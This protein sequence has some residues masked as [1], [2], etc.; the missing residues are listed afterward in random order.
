MNATRLG[1]TRLGAAPLGLAGRGSAP[2][3]AA[4]LGAAMCGYAPQGKGNT[5]MTSERGKAG[6]GQAKRGSTLQCMILAMRVLAL[7]SRA[8]HGK[9]R[10]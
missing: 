8:A 1:A 6:F 10:V 5:P 2:R 9:A 4:A 7:Q 3:G